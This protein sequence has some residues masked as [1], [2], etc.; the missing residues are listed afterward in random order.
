MVS[1]VALAIHNDEKSWPIDS[2]MVFTALSVSSTLRYPFL[3]PPIAV[4]STSG[5]R[6]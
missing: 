3:M 6:D 4:K 1:V 2:I 5:D